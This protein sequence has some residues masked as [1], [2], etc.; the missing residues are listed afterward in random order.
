M[1]RKIKKGDKG[2]STH[3]VEIKSIDTEKK[4]LEAIFSTQGVDRHGDTV[5]QDGWDLKNFKKNPVI[6]NSHNY[7]DAADVIGKASNVR[8]ENKKLIGTIK[9][10]VDQNPKAKVIFELFAGGFLKAFS[11][12]FMIK[13]F[14]EN[15]DGTTDWYTIEESELLEVS[16]VSVPANAQ[17]LAKSK[18]IDIDILNLKDNENIKKE[19]DEIPQDNKVPEAD[20]E[21]TPE[22]GNGSE[23]EPNK[24]NGEGGDDDGDQDDTDDDGEDEKEIEKGFVDL[25][26]SICKKL[27][28]KI[29]KGIVIGESKCEECSEKEIEPKK[30]SYNKKVVN[31]IKR[32]G[33]KEKRNLKKAKDIIDSLL[34]NDHDGAIIEKK[35]KEQIR[36]RKV[37]TAIRALLKSK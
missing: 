20:E 9:F 33:N 29:A 28:G 17:A 27:C 18:G 30:T 15:K 11:V 13:K 26:C 32:I 1:S 14:K 25:N 19:V 3:D 4:T 21:I 6:L 2:F 36:K 24:E 8:V 23:S 22:N 10:A 5:M 34:V 37:N 12:G 31:A 7:G 35:V 16:A